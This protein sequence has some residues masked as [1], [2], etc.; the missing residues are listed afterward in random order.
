MLVQSQLKEIL[1]F[2]CYDVGIS[3]SVDLPRIK[4]GVEY[5]TLRLPPKIIVCSFEVEIFILK[6]ISF[7]NSEFDESLTFIK[8]F[9]S[10]L[11]GS[12]KGGMIKTDDIY[13]S[14]FM[15]L[16]FRELFPPGIIFVLFTNNQSTVISSLI[17]SI[18]PDSQF[19]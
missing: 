13:S 5:P 7:V 17:F 11:K 8:K 6:G 14:Y 1:S 15:V 16:K 4:R 2:Y 10:Q 9:T 19:K 18:F 12:L 3:G